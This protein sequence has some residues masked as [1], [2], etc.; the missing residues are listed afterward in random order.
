MKIKQLIKQLS[1]FTGQKE[2]DIQAKIDSKY[3]RSFKDY[4]SIP[5][6][7]F[8]SDMMIKYKDDINQHY[9]DIEYLNACLYFYKIGCRGL[10]R[11]VTKHLNL[12]PNLPIIDLG[13]GIGLST[14]DL[15]SYFK[16]DIYYNN[17]MGKQM[18]F[19]QTIL[20]DTKVK[21]VENYSSLK[22]VDVVLAFDYFEHFKDP[23]AELNKVIRL[24][25]PKYIVES[26]DFSHAFVGHSEHYIYK[27]ELINHKRFKSLF[28]KELIFEKGYKLHP[29]SKTTKCWN[30][31]PRIWVKK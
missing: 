27:D 3:Y 6:D 17:L 16:G 14:F 20:K 13:A 8:C 11:V 26:S 21:F 5:K 19:A 30:G 24:L 10:T 15:T 12:D 9:S 29:L 25:S 18:E 22:K 28:V 23:I 4:N 7:T 2:E 31:E 1:E